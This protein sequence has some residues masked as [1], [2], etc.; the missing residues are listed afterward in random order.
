[1]AVAVTQQ[2]ARMPGELLAQCSQDLRVFENLLRGEALDEIDYLDLDWA[3]SLLKKASIDSGS[4]H[5]LREALRLS[6]DGALEV[7][8]GYSGVNSMY[9]APTYL[10]AQEVARVARSFSEIDVDGLLAPEIVELVTEGQGLDDPRTYLLEHFAALRAFYAGAS[11]RQL[12]VMM[13]WD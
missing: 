5:L 9:Q 2:L 12:A 8:P 13:W 3:P 6:T 7:M 4:P 1:M 10:G 11:D